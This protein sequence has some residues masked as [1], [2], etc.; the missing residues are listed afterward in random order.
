MQ[1]L[2]DRITLYA[3]SACMIDADTGRILYGKNPYEARAMASTTKILTCLLAL[4][5]CSIDDVVTASEYAA[6]MPDVQLNMRTGEQ[7]RL[8]D[9]L[10]SLMLESHNDTAVAIAEHV[11]GSVEKF[12]DMMTKRAREIG[13]TKSVF[14]TP[15]GLDKEVATEE[16]TKKHSTTAEELALILR[17][18]LKNEQFVAICRTKNAM[19]YNVDNGIYYTND[20]HLGHTGG[21]L[22]TEVY[23]SY[24]D[25]N[26]SNGVY[27]IIVKKIF[28]ELLGDAV[29]SKLNYYAS[30]DDSSYKRNVLFVSD[31]VQEDDFDKYSDKLIN[32]TYKFVLKDGN[33]V[34]TEYKIG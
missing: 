20:K 5:N 24:F 32:Y 8:Y 13:C 31:D 7:F 25:G 14:L 26:E 18:C 11:G 15:N 19:I 17:E 16:G 34:L 30:Y 9:L 6:S 1:E 3:I 33:Y 23:N 27:T 22:R 21:G 29:Y 10:L 28:S 2:A 12:C 4:E